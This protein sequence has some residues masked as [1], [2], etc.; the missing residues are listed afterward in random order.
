MP[1]PRP[2]G[3]PVACVRTPEVLHEALSEVRA[4][5]ASIGLVPTMGALHEGHLSLIRRARTENDRVVV[6]VFVNPTQFGPQEDLALY[7]R[8]LQTDVALAAEAGADLVFAPPVEQMYRPG[9]ATWV[10]VERL[11]EGLCGASRPGHF[12]GVCTVVTKLFNI[13]GPDRAY[14][15]EK[16]A[17]Q[18]A[19]IRRMVRDLDM[20][21]EVVACPTVREPDGLAMSSRNVRLSP[22]ARAQAPVL[23][24]ALAAARMAA[25]AGERDTEHLK[26]D[27]YEA[28]AEADLVATDYV[29]IVDAKTL[30]PLREI[31]RPALIALAVVMGDV[32]LID[33]V[34]VTEPAPA[35]DRILQR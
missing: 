21:L 14:F 4:A 31:D 10:E 29:E 28:L 35:T 17:Q 19:V 13:V 15:G 22:E 27:I 34:T 25:E 5:G 18:L 6:S 33:S 23:Y 12:R 8:D 11:G 24:Q 7:P 32:R 1:D 20:R 3:A 16:D 30:E 2:T 26:T 9:H